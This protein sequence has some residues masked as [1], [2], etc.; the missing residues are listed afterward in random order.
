MPY[1]RRVD[2]IPA[3]ELDTSGQSLNRKSVIQACISYVCHQDPHCQ[4]HDTC[5]CHRSIMH[6]VYTQS[7]E[8]TFIMLPFLL[9]SKINIK[10]WQSQPCISCTLQDL[11]HLHTAQLDRACNPG[12]WEMQC[13]CCMF[14]GGTAHIVVCFQFHSYYCRFQQD[15][16]GRAVQIPGQWLKTSTQ[17]GIPHKRQNQL[18]HIFQPHILHKCWNSLLQVFQMMFQLDNPVF[19]LNFIFS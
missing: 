15:I 17:Q 5:Q 9:D 3:V 13:C 8:T 11:A 18:M 16:S 14:Q 2:P 10:Q 12:W 7:I 1:R 19:A 6:L 4:E